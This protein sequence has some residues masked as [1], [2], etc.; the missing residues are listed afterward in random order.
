MRCWT[1]RPAKALLAAALVF[2]CAK[3]TPPAPMGPDARPAAIHPTD[4]TTPPAQAPAEPVFVKV[5]A[6]ECEKYDVF[7]GE[8]PPKG[9]IAP[10]TGIRAWHGGG[11]N[12][13]N[14]NVHDLRCTVR[15][16]TT[17]TQGRALLTLRVGQQTVAEREAPLFK[18]TA[19][20]ELVVPEA[21]WEK[22]YDRPPKPAAL[23]LPFK[24]AAFRAQV[25][26]DCEAPEKV[27]PHRWR[28][29]SVA[30]E[31]AFLA[32]FASGE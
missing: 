6:F 28:F 13:A 24:T 26:V 4:G 23:K 19:D 7:P 14:W 22:G 1:M 32:G 25:A 12:G 15:A 16:T 30:A 8:A 29:P 31:D 10:G 27:S 9:L 17:C 2:G 5:G 11:P 3:A 18:G 21:V 20:F